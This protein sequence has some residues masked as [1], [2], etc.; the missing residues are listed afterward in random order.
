MP[1]KSCV[2]FFHLRPLFSPRSWGSPDTKKSSRQMVLRCFLPKS[3]LTYVSAAAGTLASSE[4]NLM[5]EPKAPPRLLILR[6]LLVTVIVFSAVGA[7]C[8]YTGLR[9]SEYK[10]TPDGHALI[11]GLVAAHEGVYAGLFI[12]FV[13]DVIRRWRWTRG[14]VSSA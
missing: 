11:V 3:E 5:T 12:G 9:Q 6:C 7:I 13:A 8:G 4:G 14:G 2:P 10:T 1:S